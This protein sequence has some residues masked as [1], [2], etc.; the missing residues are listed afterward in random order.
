MLSSQ[1]PA[2]LPRRPTSFQYNDVLQ[3]ARNAKLAPLMMVPWSAVCVLVAVKLTDVLNYATDVPA[4]DWSVGQWIF[5]LLFNGI[6][7]PAPLFIGFAMG[8]MARHRGARHEGRAAMLL[9]LAIAA[10]WWLAIAWSAIQ[11]YLQ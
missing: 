5:N 1:S 4:T 10:T 3:L 2:T 8:A 11:D 6:V 9:N 7:L